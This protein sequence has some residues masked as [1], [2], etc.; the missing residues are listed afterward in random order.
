VLL[1]LALVSALFLP[2]NTIA[3]AEPPTATSDPGEQPTS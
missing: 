2:R 3:A 1:V